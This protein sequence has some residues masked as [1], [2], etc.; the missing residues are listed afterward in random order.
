MKVPVTGGGLAALFLMGGGG[1]P[2]PDIPRALADLLAEGDTAVT[3]RGVED[4]ATSRCYRTRV[5]LPRAQTWK[6]I[7]GL[8]AIDQMPGAPT[9]PPL[10]Q[11]PPLTL[12]ILTDTATFRLV[13]LV[14]SATIDGSTAAV[15][16]R[17]AAPNEPVS[18]NAPPP[19]LVDDPRDSIGGGGGGGGGVAP[20]PPVQVPPVPASIA[21]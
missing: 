14:G 2:E 15:R 3:L 4:C 13:E 8:T 20:P 19:N 10:D 11:I 17:I 12:E 7:V 5:E 18:I 6:L 1:G 16:L 21:P 9:D